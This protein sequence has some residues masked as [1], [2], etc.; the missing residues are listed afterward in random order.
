MFHRTFNV[1]L[2][3]FSLNYLPKTLENNL[4]TSLLLFSY[5]NVENDWCYGARKAFSFSGRGWASFR[6][7]P[8]C[9]WA[10]GDKA[11][12]DRGP[13]GFIKRIEFFILNESKNHC[14]IWTSGS[15]YMPL[16]KS[17][18]NPCPDWRSRW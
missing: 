2:I 18:R 5:R 7:G 3:D 6:R 9:G 1:W 8:T 11:Y 15:G 17:F 14:F 4:L 13:W 16:Y 10:S 12:F